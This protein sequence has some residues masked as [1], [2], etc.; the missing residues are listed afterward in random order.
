MVTEL[1]ASTAKPGAWARVSG[2]LSHAERGLLLAVLLVMVLLPSLE[3]LGRLLFRAGIPGSLL[4]TQHLTLW[5]AFLGALLAT[6]GPGRHLALRTGTLIASPRLRRLVRVYVAVLGATVCGLVGYAAAVM[7]QADAEFP[8]FL[9]GG[10]PE[11]VSELVMPAALGLMALRFVWG[12]SDGWRGRSLAALLSG[13]AIAS[14]SLAEGVAGALVWPGVGLIVLGLLLGAPVFVAMAGL[15]ALLFFS[16]GTP[17]A[18]VPTETYR[19]VASATLPA[20]PLLTL[21][22]FVL[23]AGGAPKR[24]LRLAR[25]AGGF[26][27]GGMAV[28]TCFVCAGFTAFTGGSGVTILALGGLFLPML[29][30]ERY[31][32]GFSLGLV[33][34]SGSLGLLLPP[35]LPVILYAVVAQA[36]VEELF[37]AGFLPGMVLILVVAA[38]G[39]WVGHRSRAPRQAFSGRELG[40]ALW[41][42]KW[43]MAIPT[44]VLVSVLTGIATI[45]EAAALAAVLALLSQTVM[46]RDLHPLKDLPRVCLDASALVGA[47]LILLSMAMGLTS[48]LVEAE[49]PAALLTWTRAHIESPVVFL[50]VLNAALLVLGSV[51]E[52]YSAIV[53]L[54][55]LLA[56]LAPAYGIHPLHLGIVFLANLELGFLFPPMGLNLILS[57]TRFGQPLVRLY[58]VVLPFLLISAVGLLLITY[59]PALT[60]GFLALVRGG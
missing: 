7:V 37:I 36:S 57:S 12:A 25:A 23:A 24:L 51:L 3:I 41:A 8:R 29:I 6:A 48:Y 14:L 55:P 45:V 44:L 15:A 32:E 47:V 9:P 52:I 31:P 39:V 27:P 21:A 18:A 58:K 49:I 56:P 40:R 13:G 50:L 19:L 53:I 59:V 11:W 42:A 16:S 30:A 35:S 17:I 10:F 28:M 46:F 5:A 34:C 33:T 38:Y 2:W 54:A 60:T 26:M 43:E 20:V 4:Y 22:G 1:A